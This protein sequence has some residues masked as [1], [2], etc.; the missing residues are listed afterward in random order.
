MSNT[1]KKNPKLDL[2]KST[3]S[4]KRVEKMNNIAADLKAKIADLGDVSSLEDDASFLLHICTLVENVSTKLKGA[5]KKDLVIKQMITTFPT[6]NNQKDLARIG[7]LI[8]FLVENS[9][10][11]SIGNVEVA[12]SNFCSFLNKKLL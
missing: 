10:V 11:K 9:L 3:S 2:V 6:L 1:S 8:D 12:T 4:L 7:K 5:D